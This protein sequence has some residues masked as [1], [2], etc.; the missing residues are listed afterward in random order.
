MKRELHQHKVVASQEIAECCL[1]CG[2]H[3]D[4]GYHA[5]FLNLDNGQ[6]MAVMTPSPYLQSYPDR[7]HGGVIST[8][9]DELLSRAI[10]AMF[11][12]VISVTLELSL[13]FRT[14]VPF[15]EEIHGIAWV[16]KDRSRIYDAA[17]EIILPDGTVAVQA[18]GRFLKTDPEELRGDSDHVAFLTDDR[19]YPEYVM[20]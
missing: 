13:T 11:P 12:K 18:T 10:Q 8:L 3:N 5:Q 16:T 1:V 19:P 7:L 6:V 2:K 17:G 4:Q 15:D 9:M 14:P 20:A